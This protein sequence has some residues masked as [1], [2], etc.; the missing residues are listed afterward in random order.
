MIHNPL[1]AGWIRH[2]APFSTGLLPLGTGN[3]S[4]LHHSAGQQQPFHSEYL[5]TKD[6]EDDFTVPF[7]RHCSCDLGDI[8][9]AVTDLQ[10]H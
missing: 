7:I 9:G 8:T 2:R 10:T 3:Y 1:P 4:C 6:T 5:R